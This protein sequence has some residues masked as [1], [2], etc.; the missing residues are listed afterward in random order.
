MHDVQ[1]ATPSALAQRDRRV[2][3]DSAPLVSNPGTIP[4]LS[5]LPDAAT[6]VRYRS[7]GTFGLGLGDDV[8]GRTLGYDAFISYS[9]AL[10]GALAR[11]L[12]TGV[13]RFAK[14]WYRPRA[15]RVF[16]DTVSLS[17][18]PDLWSSIETALASSAWL[19]LMASPEAARSPWVNREV[20]WWRANKSPYRLLLVLTEGEFSWADDIGG[21]DGPSA[22]APSCS[23][24]DRIGRFG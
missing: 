5:A 10:D 18:S 9:H 1:P 17:A 2:R 13:E 22:R 12:Q 24:N 19:V 4:E 8:A 20:A 14:P 15:L 6:G 11:A 3:G 7:S 21:G 16:R 23:G